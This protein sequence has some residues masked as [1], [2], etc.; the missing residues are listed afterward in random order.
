MNKKILFLI[1]FIIVLLLGTG[2]SNRKKPTVTDS[3]TL[4]TAIIITGAAARIP[5]EAALLEKLY[6]NGELSQVEFIGGASS[7]ALN[8][9]ILNGILSKKITWSQYI[10]WLGK[11]RKADLC[12]PERRAGTSFLAVHGNVNPGK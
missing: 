5:Q 1:F 9:V 4:G 12:R 6:Q 11:I 10:S 7:G 2:C 3:P 8:A